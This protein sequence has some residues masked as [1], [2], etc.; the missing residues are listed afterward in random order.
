MAGMW[1]IYLAFLIPYFHDPPK[2][3]PPKPTVYHRGN[4][5]LQ[6]LFQEGESKPLLT[7][8]NGA[9]Q[10]LA[11]EMSDPFELPLWKRTAALITIFLVFLLKLVLELVLS[12][13]AP[14]TGFYF[15]WSPS[16]AVWFLAALGCLVLPAIG[17][18]TYASS[19]YEDRYLILNLATL[20]VVYTHF[21]KLVDPAKKFN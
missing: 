10:P 6:D 1:V 8:N 11:V 17:F 7:K 19:V 21:T 5:K 16:M 9:P 20:V 14:I 12:S 4:D 15:D 2:P 13:C 18:V 3:A